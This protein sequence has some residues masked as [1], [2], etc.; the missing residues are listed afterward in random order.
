MIVFPTDP[1]QVAPSTGTIRAGGTDSVHRGAAPAMVIDLRDLTVLR[2]IDVP[3]PPSKAPPAGER[4]AAPPWP[5]VPP[6]PPPLPLGPVRIGATVTLRE[7]ASDRVIATHW[8]GLYQAA[9]GLANPG[10]RAVATVGGNL[11][12]DNRCAWFRSHEFT[13]AR[14]AGV[15]CPALEGGSRDLMVFGAGAC[16][17]PGASTLGLAFT[18]FD[19]SY[20]GGDGALAPVAGLY[21]GLGPKADHALPAGAWITAVELPLPWAGERS[22]WLRIA[23][24][25]RAEWP[26]VE[27]VARVSV[28]AG[29]VAQAR[30]VLGGVGRGPVRCAATEAALVGKPLD[31]ATIAAA[32]A[33]A[34]EGATPSSNVSYKLPLIVGIVTEALERL[35]EGA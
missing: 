3:S 30:V 25:A 31:A 26:I 32:A 34:T 20:V 2:R 18:A 24:R 16:H 9:G 15:G 29:L 8:P 14:K 10:V 11:L 35:R 21:E 4:R 5:P 1:A 28:Q 22:A 6:P 12:Q 27:V 23:G 17:A 33:V 19:A 13:C 7:L